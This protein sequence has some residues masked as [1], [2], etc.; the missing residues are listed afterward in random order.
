[1][2]APDNALVL[3]DESKDTYLAPPCVKAEAA[4]LLQRVPL[5]LAQE[6]KFQSDDQCR[7][8]DDFVQEG[9]SL[10]GLLLQKV[11]ILGPLPS[12]WNP[13]GSWNW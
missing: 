13:D 4:G 6:L 7:N 11:G 9:R 10:S 1:M 8:S 2:V 12:R 5:S 3:L